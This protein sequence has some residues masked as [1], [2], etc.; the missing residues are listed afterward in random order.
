MLVGAFLR[1]WLCKRAS[2]NVGVTKYV[3]QRIA[4]PQGR[5]IDYGV[6]DFLATPRTPLAHPFSTSLCFAYVG[7]LVKEKGLGLLLNAARHLKDEGYEFR[8]KFVGDGPERASLETQVAELSLQN[9]VQF[10]GF[11]WGETLESGLADVAVVVMPS[12]W[13]ETAGLAAIE[14]MMRARLVIASDIGGLGEVVGDAGLKFPAGDVRGLVARMQQVLNNPGVVAELGSKARAR[15]M[16]LF[17]KDRMVEQQCRLF[18]EISQ[19]KA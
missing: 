9:Q 1:H 16:E 13:E 12:V 2:A 7:R 18:Q 15:A 14:Q 10:T 17:H 8:L 5:T 11:L 19:D 3:S 4:L 6:T